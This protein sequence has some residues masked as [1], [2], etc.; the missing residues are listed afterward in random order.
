MS[1]FGWIKFNLQ[2]C[3]TCCFILLHDSFKA[4]RKFSVFL[5]PFIHDI[6]IDLD[7]TRNSL[8]TVVKDSS[9]HRF[10]YICYSHNSRYT[11][12]GEISSL[13]YD[14]HE[15]VSSLSWLHPFHSPAGSMTATRFCTYRMSSID[16]IFD[17]GAAENGDQIQ[18]K[19]VKYITAI[20][21]IDTISSILNS[22]GNIHDNV[23]YK[24][25]LYKSQMLSEEY[26]MFHTKLIPLLAYHRL[27][28]LLK[29]LAGIHQSGND[30]EL[31]T[32][33][34]KELVRLAYFSSCWSYTGHL[35]L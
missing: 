31:V 35:K 11:V 2:F 28:D 3:L 23:L 22:E 8:Q 24:L 27:F 5:K 1:P 15:R 32:N 21:A 17:G 20:E 7:I 19:S 14:L 25:K 26:R 6:P 16:N 34:M 12:S 30:M 13:K 33:I 4:K 9:Y 29:E 18:I 10:E